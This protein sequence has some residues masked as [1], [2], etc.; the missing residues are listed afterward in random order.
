MLQQPK[1]LVP[2]LESLNFLYFNAANFVTTLNCPP[3]WSQNCRCLLIEHNDFTRQQVH[4]D[5]AIT[6]KIIIFLK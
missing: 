5:L 1:H 6:V 4:L 2:S 3:T